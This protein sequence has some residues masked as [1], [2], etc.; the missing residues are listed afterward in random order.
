VITETQQ[1]QTLAYFERST[2]VVPISSGARR[3]VLTCYELADGS[4]HASWLDERG[5]LDALLWRLQ[6]AFAAVGAPHRLALKPTR[7]FAQPDTGKWCATFEKF[8]RHYDF[9]ATPNQAPLRESTLNAVSW[10]QSNKHDTLESCR[11][12]LRA[13]GSFVPTSLRALAPDPFVSPHELFRKVAGD[14]FVLFQRDAYSVPEEYSGKTVWLQL[15]DGLLTVSSQQGRMLARYPVGDGTGRVLLD[16]AHFEGGRIRAGRQTGP[17]TKLFR[18]RFPSHDRFLFALLAQRRQSAAAT[19]RTLLTLASRHPAPALDH[20]FEQALLYNN[21]SH[22]FIEGL[23][24]TETR[25]RPE[26]AK[27]YEQGCLF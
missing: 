4:Q 20:A 6:I 17:L 19:L 1:N 14:G 3:M 2:V 11:E 7:P 8:Q 9:Q 15:R 21:F 24:T 10:A 27:T 18:G 25:P 12:A 13:L 23:I 5:S 22:R 16:L 26:D